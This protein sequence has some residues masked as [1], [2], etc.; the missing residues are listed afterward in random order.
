MIVLQTFE[1][2]SVVKSPQSALG[3][4]SLLLGSS[5]GLVV[6]LCI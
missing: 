2:F 3:S 6:E 5:I 4:V 1:V